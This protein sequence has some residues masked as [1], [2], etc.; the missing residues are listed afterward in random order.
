ME[1]AED[2]LQDSLLGTNH[3]KSHT[4]LS[5]FSNDEI[6]RFQKRREEGYD[7]ETD[8]R[9]NLW[10]SL[11]KRSSKDKPQPANSLLVM[12]Q[13]SYKSAVTKL[14][15]TVPSNRKMPTFVPKTS[16]CVITSEECRKKINEKARQKEE[17]E[18]MKQQKKLL[19]LQ[20]QEE[21]RLSGKFIM[22]I[23]KVI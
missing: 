18:R 22:V 8:L 4:D 14:I 17:S 5:M 15:E 10:L 7:I 9:Y 11:Q 2:S 20:K 1:D 3:R 23:S 16:A 21:K 12:P 6:M 13:L 19:R